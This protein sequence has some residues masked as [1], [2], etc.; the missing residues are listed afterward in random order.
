MCAWQHFF[1]CAVTTKQNQWCR[2]IQNSE[3][4]HIR[5]TGLVSLGLHIHR[6]LS[7]VCTWLQVY[8]LSFTGKLW[9]SKKMLLEPKNTINSVIKVINYIKANAL[10]SGLFKRLCD[11]MDA[12]HKCLLLHTEVRW[13]TKGRSLVRIWVMKA[14]AETYSRK[15]T[16][17][18][19]KLWSMVD[20]SDKHCMSLSPITPKWTGF[21]GGKQTAL[22]YKNKAYTKEKEEKN[23]AYALLDWWS[24]FY[25]WN[26]AS[27]HKDS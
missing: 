15:K 7:G 18:Q 26:G 16:V 6:E 9:L 27:D 23:W 1:F 24:M 11:E 25:R 20:I 3:W 2:T 10:N 8:A 14:C 21:L 12:K 4:L 19:T 17:I 5:K 22:T 13:L